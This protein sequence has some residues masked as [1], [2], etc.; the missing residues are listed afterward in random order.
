MK[1]NNKLSF[2]NFGRLKMTLTI[3]MLGFLTDTIL[4]NWMLNSNNGF[5]ESN[6]NFYPEI[7]IPLMVLNYIVFDLFIPRKIIFDNIFYTLSLLQWSGPV[8]NLLVLFNI[9]QGIDFF[10]ALPFIFII[11]FVVL[12]YK[13]N[14]ENRILISSR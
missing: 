13:I 12:N 8:Q 10:Y 4:T 5:Y 14:R 2:K 11:S 9:I 6:Q 1:I 7:G 3:A